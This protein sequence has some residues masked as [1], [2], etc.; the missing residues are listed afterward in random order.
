MALWRLHIRTVK[1]D[2]D[3]DPVE[4]CK[5]HQV[6]GIGWPVDKKPKTKEEYWALG[7]ERYGD[8]GWR[9]ACNAFLY[10]MSNNDLVWIRDFC[11]I[12]YVGRIL[13]DWEYRDEEEFLKAGIVNTRKCLLFKIGTTISGKIINCFRARATLQQIADDTAKLFSKII[14][15]KFVDKDPKY[16]ISKT[17]LDIFSLLSSED[18]ED[19]V[20]LYL[21]LE[22]NYLVIPSSRSKRNDTPFYE[23]ELISRTD[24][25]SAYL[26]VK[27]GLVVIN[28]EDYSSFEK[29]IYLFSPAGYQ[30]VNTSPNIVLLDKK[31]IERF[32]LAKKDIMPLHIKVWLDFVERLD[33]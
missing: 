21:Q 1:P 25:Q 3:V 32:I 26:Q 20:G 33:L 17:N 22:Q 29:K 24:G 5:R 10:K 16:S 27:S 9:K 19:I 30:G 12:Y 4:T 14:F 11:G 2:Y 15:N 7:E 31:T 8:S 23:F 28:L 18:L 13:D 6:V